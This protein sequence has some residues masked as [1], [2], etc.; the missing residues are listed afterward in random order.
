MSKVKKQPVAKKNAKKELSKVVFEK[1]S[2]SLTDFHLTEK[3]LE[4][5]LEKVSKRLASD[6]VKLLNKKEAPESDKTVRRKK[7]VKKEKLVVAE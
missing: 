6:I 7:T 3:K 5:R 1:L 2:G 4:N